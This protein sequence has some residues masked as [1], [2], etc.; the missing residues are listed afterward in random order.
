MI[1]GMLI[2]TWVIRLLYAGLTFLSPIDTAWSTILEF[3]NYEWIVK[4]TSNLTTPGK[5]YWSDRKSDV[6]VD[7]EGLHLSITKNEKDGKWYC[8]EVISK[9]SFGYGTYIFKL[10]TQLDDHSL[11]PNVVLGLF[12]WDDNS[13]LTNA[14]SEIDIEIAKWAVSDANTLHYS[15]QPTV[16]A[17]GWE[18]GCLKRHRV[19][20]MSLDSND[21]THIF[22]WHP[23]SIAFTSYQ[24]H[25]YPPLGPTIEG[26]WIYDLKARNCSKRTQ[27]C[28][29]DLIGIPAATAG[30]KVHIN[31]WL[32]DSD[33]DDQGNPPQKDQHVVIREFQFIPYDPSVPK[34]LK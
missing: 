6:W 19:Y 22:R 10:A 30:T 12:T 20:P 16:F 27:W 28:E 8:S 23:D 18:P 33:G 14:N 32:C 17:G 13:C 26:Q 24:G 29:S 9:K 11:D 3:S 15:V 25:G 7:E 1:S 34:H 21:S 31:L 2:R 4:A 5:N